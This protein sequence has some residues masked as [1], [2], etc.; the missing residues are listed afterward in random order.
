MN[1]IFPVNH[2]EV[3]LKHV[4]IQLNLLAMIIISKPPAVCKLPP[5]FA[6]SC[7]S[8]RHAVFSHDEGAA[9]E[10]RAVELGDGPLRVRHGREPH[11][12]E[13]ESNTR[14]CRG[15]K[16]KYFGKKIKT[17]EGEILRACGTA[18]GAAF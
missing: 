2:L 15:P 13:K 7:T 10:E 9:H 3:A 8:S 16:K 6:A 4:A 11:L 18:C 17:R 14:D 12:R 1:N 5:K